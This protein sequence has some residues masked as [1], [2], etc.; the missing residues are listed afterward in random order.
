MSYFK[1]SWFGIFLIVSLTSCTSST[2][3]YNLDQ[4]NRVIKLPKVL[5]EISGLEYVSKDTL[6][7]VQDEKASVYFIDSKTGKIKKQINFGKRG[8]Y[9]GLAFYKKKIF[10]L[11][12]DGRISRVSNKGVVKDFN[13]SKNS[14]FDFEGLC[15]DHKN[16]RLLIACKKH[17]KPKKNKEAIF[18]YAFSLKDKKCLTEPVFKIARKEIGKKF[19]PSG[20]AID[21][22]GVIHIPSAYSKQ[23]L[24]MTAQGEVLSVRKLKNKN[25]VQAEGVCFGKEGELYI[26]NEGGNGRSNLMVFG[27]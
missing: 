3:D 13:F 17:G 8:D 26:S 20:I 23:L 12:S 18:I 25:F 27:N 4:P 6:A 14:G 2:M 1:K 15:V 21:G 19:Q 16:D 9:E 11:R 7:C 10:V 24:T 22:K 5:K